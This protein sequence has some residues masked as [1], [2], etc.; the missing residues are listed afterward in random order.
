MIKKFLVKAKVA[1]D[2]V[3]ETV[4]TVVVALTVAYITSP[5]PVYAGDASYL[6]PLNKLKTV[7]FSIIAAA[8]IIVLGYGGLK[9]AVSFQKMDQNGEHQAIYT[10]IAGGIMIGISAFVAALM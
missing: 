4:K 7:M 2:K 5:I 6:S 1:T 9:F 3:K 8:G 10:M